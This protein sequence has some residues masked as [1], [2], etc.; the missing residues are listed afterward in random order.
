MS[1]ISG[2]LWYDLNQNSLR[3]SD[4]VGLPG[5]TIYIDENQDNQPNSNELTAQT[6]ADGSYTFS[7]LAPGTYTLATLPTESWQ[8]IF[9]ESASQTVSLGVEEALD[10]I[11]FGNS[12]NEIFGFLSFQQYVRFLTHKLGIAEADLPDSFAPVAVG[13]IAIPLLF[14]NVYYL[15]QY[16]DVAAAIAAG[17]FANTYDH[18]LQVGLDHGY[19]PS[20]LYNEAF[21]LEQN[22]DVQAAVNAGDLASGLRHFLEMGHLEGKD[23]SPLFSQT[24]YLNNYPDVAEGL[25]TADPTDPAFPILP[26]WHSAF[27]HYLE[28]WEYPSTLPYEPPPNRVPELFLYDEAF[29]LENNPDVVTAIEAGIYRDGLDHFLQQGQFQG[30]DP[31]GLFNE[32]TYLANHPEAAAAV[33]SGL[34][35]SGFEHYVLSDQP[36]PTIAITGPDAVSEGETITFTVSLSVPNLEVVAV[37]YSTDVTD[38]GDITADL[39]TPGQDFAATQGTLTFLPGETQKSVE[40]PTYLDFLEEPDEAIALTLSA[41]ENA[42]LIE[43][44]AAALILDQPPISP[45]EIE[46]VPGFFSFE[47]YVRAL[48]LDT[49]ISPDQLPA[50][51]ANQIVGGLSLHQVFDETFYLYNNPDVACAL[52]SGLLSSGYE[53]FAQF[54]QFEGRNPSLLYDEAYYLGQNSDVAI[55]VELGQIASGFQHFALYGHREGRRP[56]PWFDEAAYRANHPDVAAAIATGSFLSGFQHF[57]AFGHQEHREPFLSLFNEQDYLDRYPDVAAAVANQT[58]PDGFTHYFIHGKREGRIPSELFN[59]RAYL[60]LNPDIQSQ[61]N[62]VGSWATFPLYP[63]ALEQYIFEG[64]ADGRLTLPVEQPLP[65]VSVTFDGAVSEGEPLRFTA[66]LSA[67]SSHPVS[68]NYRTKEVYGVAEVGAIAGE[69]YAQVVPSSQGGLF[70]S[71]AAAV[72]P[73]SFNT[74]TFAPGETQKTIALPTFADYDG[75]EGREVFELWLFSPTNAALGT[76]SAQG[77]IEDVDPAKLRLPATLSGILPLDQYRQLNDWLGQTAGTR[78]IPPVVP[79]ETGDTLPLA[80]FFDEVY[81]LSRNS[82]VSCAYAAGVISSGYEYFVQMGQFEP[83]VNFD[84]RSLDLSALYNEAYYLQN[85]PDVQSAIWQGWIPNGLQHF[86]RWGHREGR[87]P[88][89]VFSQQDYLTNHPDVRDAVEQGFIGSAFEHF[90]RFGLS[91]GRQ[92][93]LSL[94]DENFYRTQNPDVAEAIARGDFDSGFDHYLQFGQGEQRNPSALFDESSYLA[95]NPDVAS[96]V[97]DGLIPSGFLH[98]VLQGRGEGRAVFT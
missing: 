40:I 76:A 98:Y 7:E 13:E 1:S 78:F 73:T 27:E 34:Y 91:E 57:T 10:G 74:L 85:N 43:P 67:P 48:T 95:L 4:E 84:D 92:P 55:A 66:V 62:S 14:D 87:D 37:G 70:I 65:S 19:H 80:L 11:N 15:K 63:S 47:Q 21:Y 29:Y 77:I 54:G 32:V 2:I 42:V 3:D 90:V 71:N 50:T 56:S 25:A 17:E 9:P 64:R 36:A 30:R 75:T 26:L 89:G 79:E 59:P 93:Q 61:V 83:G 86:I 8:Q 81:Y 69:D 53:H 20:I 6:Q 31:S 22:P 18:F 88:S 41:P 33:A 35:A 44:L 23:P 49:G 97:E 94:F 58:F 5:W 24:D 16:P 51:W 38:L 96:F 46:Q 45:T 12:T 72:Q 82:E 28:E 68:V 60:T 52:S 39:A